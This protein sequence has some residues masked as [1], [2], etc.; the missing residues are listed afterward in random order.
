M[1]PNNVLR[2]QPNLLHQEMQKCNLPLNFDNL[3]NMHVPKHHIPRIGVNPSVPPYLLPMIGLS[4]FAVE[5]ISNFPL[6]EHSQAHPEPKL[7]IPAF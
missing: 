2:L 3:D 7:V 6:F 5:H 1:F 4:W